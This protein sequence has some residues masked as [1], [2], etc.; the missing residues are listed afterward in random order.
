MHKIY[1][2][3]H[4]KHHCLSLSGPVITVHMTATAMF[5]IVLFY[6]LPQALGKT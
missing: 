6:Y 3:H 2:L 1:I 5:V 4:S